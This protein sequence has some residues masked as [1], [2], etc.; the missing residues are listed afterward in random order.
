M[1][2][3]I[4]LTLSADELSIFVDALEAE[5]EDYTD[6]AQEAKEEGQSGQAAAFNSAAKRVLAVLEKMRGLSAD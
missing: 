2:D 5:L 1:S 3:T 6:A 4:N